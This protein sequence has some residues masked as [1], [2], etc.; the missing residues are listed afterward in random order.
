MRAKRGFAKALGLVLLVALLTA[1][2]GSD[3]GGGST[4]AGTEQADLSGA[5]FTVGSKEFTEQLV[6]G[7]ITIQTLEAAGATVDDK[8]KLPGSVQARTALEGGQIDMY[9]EYTGTGW[10]IYLKH[11]KPIDDSQKQYEAVAEEDMKKND[12]AWLPPAP[13]DNT[14]AIA[15]S[16]EVLK[17]DG[18]SK[19]SDLPGLI[20]DDPEAATLCVGTEFAVR[21]D[22][23]PGLEKH[24]GFQWPADQIAKVTEG[25]IYSEVDKGDTC[26]YGEVFA[27]DSRIAGLGLATLEDDKQFFAIYNP[28]LTVNGKVFDKYGPELKKIFAPIAAKLDTETLLKLNAQVDVDG[29]PEEAV[30]EKW[31][32][33]EGLI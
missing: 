4:G 28:S 17:E 5:S 1:A 30:A 14:Y 13:A 23:L 24:Y 26:R 25:V 27:T 22:G 16:E 12:I 21:D 10:I 29:L 2:C 9:W 33:E 7:Q 3:E 32:T 20:K 18:V 19:L 11:T 31:L 8:T 6:L 15:A